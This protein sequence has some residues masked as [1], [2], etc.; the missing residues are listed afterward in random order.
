MQIKAANTIPAIWNQIRTALTC[1][2][3][4]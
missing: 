4:C 2:V 1:A 3:Q